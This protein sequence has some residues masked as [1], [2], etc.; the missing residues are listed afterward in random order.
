MSATIGKNLKHDCQQVIIYAETL[1]GQIGELA[2]HINNAATALYK[3]V[4][5]LGHFVRDVF[6]VIEC[7][8]LVVVESG[9]LSIALISLLMT[10]ATLAVAYVVDSIT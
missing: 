2:S 5:W 6:R 4:G 3:A 8:S 9:R 1:R 7:A 10:A